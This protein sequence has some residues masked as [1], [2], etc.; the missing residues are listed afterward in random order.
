MSS[1]KV[2]IITGASRGI[3]NVV[4]EGLAE[5]GYDVVLIAR[6]ED[7]LLELEKQIKKYGVKSKIICLDITNFEAMT[8]AV[9]DVIKQWGRVDILVNN[10]GIFKDGSLETSLEDYQI[11][12]DVNFKAQL[13]LIKT[14]MPFMQSQRSGYVFNIASIA[15]KIGY[16]NIGAYTSSKFAL[17]GLSE[18]LYDEFSVQGIKITS[19][20]PGY[21]ATDMAKGAE[22]S[23]TEMIQ[24]Q[25]F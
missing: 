20:C 16:A 13:A 8:N 25:T 12:F 21:V 11:L 7:Q 24:P 6:T 15:G 3:G 5:D 17:V 22:I 19:I 14:V 4:A 2:A 18:S 9:N 1:R 23:E 10:A